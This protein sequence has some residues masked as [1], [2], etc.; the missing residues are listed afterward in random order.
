MDEKE[1]AEVIG[2]MASAIKAG[3]VEVFGPARSHGDGSPSL[4]PEY[5]TQIKKLMVA[6]LKA[7]H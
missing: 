3:L 6:W 4:P 5:Q 2:A 1:R 7:S